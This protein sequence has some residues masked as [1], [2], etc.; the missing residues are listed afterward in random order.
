MLF[1]GK[2]FAGAVECRHSLCARPVKPFG[3]G[4]VVAVAAHSQGPY[5]VAPV[6]VTQALIGS[7][8]A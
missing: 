2:F 3:R 4:P 1:R 8:T 6:V 7:W 5:P